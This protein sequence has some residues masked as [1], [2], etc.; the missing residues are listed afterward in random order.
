M[1]SSKSFRLLHLGL[2]GLFV[3]SVMAYA[4]DFPDLVLSTE[5]ALEMAADL[6]FG[7][8]PRE[9]NSQV[10][11]VF[12]PALYQ[13][14]GDQRYLLPI[15]GLQYWVSSNLTLLGGV[16]GSI[17]DGNVVQFS[18]IGFR[19]FPA[20]MN[21]GPF[22]PEIFM[23]QNRVEGLSLLIDRTLKD[24]LGNEIDVPKE[25]DTR[26]DSK[27]NEFGLGYQ[28]RIKNFS[29]ALAA[30]LIYQ[31]TFTGNAGKLTDKTH[32]LSFTIGRNVYKNLQLAIHAKIGPLTTLDLSESIYAGGIQL[33]LPI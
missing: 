9:A 14:V 31:R 7:S 4:Q 20:T 16:G 32:L 1:D 22:M 26:Y 30:I 24:S 11:L 5:T 2:H 3:F 27:W 13:P 12:Y 33:Y 23:S 21:L 6:T 25:Y 29:L 8:L 18:R 19:Y 10:D 17:A 28:G 15:V